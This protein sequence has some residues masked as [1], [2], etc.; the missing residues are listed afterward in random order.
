MELKSHF[1]SECLARILI[2]KQTIEFCRTFKCEG[3]LSRWPARLSDP[4]VPPEGTPLFAHPRDA[5]RDP[6]RALYCRLRLHTCVTHTSRRDT[7]RDSLPDPR[8]RFRTFYES[9]RIRYDRLR[10]VRKGRKGPSF[11]LRNRVAATG[12]EQRIT[13]QPFVKVSDMHLFLNSPLI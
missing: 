5:R 3:H 13:A 1:Y 6:T 8:Q 4:H 7:H 12:F 2:A 10:K 11:R 9:R